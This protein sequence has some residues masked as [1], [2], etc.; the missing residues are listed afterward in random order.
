MVALPEGGDRTGARSGGRS[1]LPDLEGFLA[2]VP[3]S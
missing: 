1:D 2:R 3:P